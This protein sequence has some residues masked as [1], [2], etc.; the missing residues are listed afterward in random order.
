MHT[1]L[2]SNVW[3]TSGGVLKS[4][5]SGEGYDRGGTK[6][7]FGDLAEASGGVLKCSKMSVG[8]GTKIGVL[9]LFGLGVLK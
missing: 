1:S 4:G 7:D 9:G 3:G 8:G 2:L 6:M 5:I